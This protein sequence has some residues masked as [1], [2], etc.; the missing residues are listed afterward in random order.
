LVVGFSACL[1]ALFAPVSAARLDAGWGRVLTPASG[2][3]LVAGGFTHVRWSALPPGTKEF[4]LLLSVD[5][6]HSY[7]LRL[8]PQLD[9][10]LGVYA[11]RV[12]NLPAPLARLRLRVGIDGREVECPPSEPFTIVPIDTEPR[13]LVEHRAG[14]WWPAPSSLPVTTAV[15]VPR[16]GLEAPGLQSRHRAHVGPPRRSALSASSFHLPS[17]EVVGGARLLLVDHPPVDRNPTFFPL[18]P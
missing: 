1:F 13:A 12:P 4:E 16:P 14:E 5:G 8:T 7:L 10:S 6:G 2:H 17:V 9:P 3:R 18:R 11:W 15:I